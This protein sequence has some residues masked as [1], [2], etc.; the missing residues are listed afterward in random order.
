M[1]TLAGA[2]RCSSIHDLIEE[3]MSARLNPVMPSMPLGGRHVKG[4]IASFEWGWGRV[5]LLQTTAW[6]ARHATEGY[7]EG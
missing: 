6:H 4:E 3:Q 1:A 7:V 5:M 2:S